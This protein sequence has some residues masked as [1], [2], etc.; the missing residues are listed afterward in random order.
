MAPPPVRRTLASLVLIPLLPAV[1][2][3][4]LAAQSVLLRLDPPQ[5]AVSRYV[6]HAEMRMDSPMGR[7]QTMMVS[8]VYT[9]VTVVAAEGDEREYETVTDSADIDF[10][11]MPM[12]AQNVPDVTGETLAMRLTTRG[13]IVGMGLE[14]SALPPEA[15]QVAA[16]MVSGG[17][18]MLLPEHPVSPGDTWNAQQG[19]EALGAMG[20]SMS[21]RVDAVYTLDRVDG[22]VAYLSFAGPMTMSGSGMPF[23]GSGTMTGA[24]SLDTARGRLVA[25]E[26]RMDVDVAMQG[27]S[28]AMRQSITMGLLDD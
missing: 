28:V 12:M 9:T 27:M 22:D 1:L 7:D 5:G 2:A 8:D 6:T 4:P 26:V 16:Q 17:F 21:I 24:L 14:G 20:G 10:P 19:F 11:T 13:R 3:A 25:S 15:Q 18:G 23:A